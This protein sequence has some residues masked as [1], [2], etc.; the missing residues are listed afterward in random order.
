MHDAHRN[1]RTWHPEVE[2]LESMTLLSGLA[3]SSPVVAA[4]VVTP[5]GAPIPIIVALNGTTRGV[6]HTERKAPDTGTSYLVNTVGRFDDYGPAYV[7]GELHSLGNVKSGDAT[8]TLHV[9]LPGG[10]LTLRLTG[11]EQKGLSKLPGE[12]TFVITEGTGKFHN[13]VGDPVGKGVVDVDLKPDSKSKGPIQ[14]G[15][16]TLTFHSRPVVVA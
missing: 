15:Q 5:P 13:K 11:P 10:T 1:R 4:A 16:V 12:F 6:Y 8:G 14:F 9:I 7:Y 2:A 3:I